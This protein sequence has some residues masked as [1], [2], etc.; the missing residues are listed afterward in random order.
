MIKGEAIGLRA[1]S[2]F[3]L[4]KL[5]GPV[6][7]QEGLNAAAIPYVDKIDFKAVKFSTAEEAIAKLQA[8]LLDAR[9][10]LEDDPIR[11]TTRNVNLNQYAYE[12]YN[13]LVDHRGA[14]MNYYTIIA[15]Q[16]MVAQ[17]AGDSQAAATYAEEIISELE[18]RDNSIHLAT[19][20]ELSQALNVRL[21]ME[22]IFSLVIPNIRIYNSEI[23]PLVENTASSSTSPY[24]FPNYTLLYNGLYNATEHGSLN[25][26]RLINWFALSINSSST[27]KLIKY[28][29]S[30]NYE[31]TNTDVAML[32][33]SKL[34]GIHQMYMIAAEEYAKSNPAKAIAYLNKVRTARGINVPLVLGESR[35]EAHIK[36]LIFEEVRKESIGEGTMFAEY[37]RLFRAIPRATP[38]A[39]NIEIFKL[40]IPT[41]ENLYNPQK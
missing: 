25:D 30:E 22:S 35:N 18:A 8:E 10:L 9:A 5:F 31:I 20:G 19:A 2:H 28:H 27:R 33:E 38:I 11:T 1:F 17:W 23:N 6:I 29:F 32:F 15:L 13:S 24:L 37:K 40:P 41:D 34:I 36:N 21:P 4:L 39:P 16:A 3:Q 7:S 14:R 12:K 26:T